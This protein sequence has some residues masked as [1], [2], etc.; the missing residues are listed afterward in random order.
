[1][2]TDAAQS[3]R[4][5][6]Q[7]YSVAYFS[8]GQTNEWT[9]TTERAE[10]L[11]DTLGKGA[12]AYSRGLGW[13]EQ[14]QDDM[15]QATVHVFLEVPS[16]MEGMLDHPEILLKMRAAARKLADGRFVAEN[17]NAVIEH[18]EDSSV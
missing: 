2:A 15:K 1:M 3:G 7:M 11:R 6:R 5:L 9:A 13:A 10:L 8:R 18:D 4:G 14:T 12:V 16:E 17:P